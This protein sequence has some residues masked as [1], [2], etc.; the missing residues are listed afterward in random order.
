MISNILSGLQNARILEEHTTRFS[1]MVRF[2]AAVL[3]LTS[4][5]GNAG[6]PSATCPEG[7][8]LLSFTDTH[9]SAGG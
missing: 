4:C 7:F 2:P 3:C 8:A 9:E 6:R 5:G 1:G